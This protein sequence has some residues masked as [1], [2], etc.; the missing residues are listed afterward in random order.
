MADPLSTGAVL[1]NRPD[2]KAAAGQ[3]CE[4]TVWL[5]GPKGVAQFDHLPDSDCQTTSGRLESSGICVMASSGQREEKLVIDA[6]PLGHGN[7][8]HG[9]AD[10]LSIELAINGRRFLADSGTR[11]YVS[12][13]GDRNRFRGTAAHNT[14]EVD[15]IEQGEPSGPFAWK[16]LPKVSVDR[17]IMGSTFD[18]FSGRHDGY[19][20]LP[21]PVMHKRSVFYLK[22]RFWLVLD[23]VEGEGN[24]Q[25]AVRWHASPATSL[26]SVGPGKAVFKR[27]EGPVLALLTEQGQEWHPEIERADLS[28]VYG[29]AEECLVLRYFTETSLPAELATLLNPLGLST[30]AESELR[31]FSLFRQTNQDESGS[32]YLYEGPGERHRI[33][34]SGR[35]QPWAMNLWASDARLLYC[36]TADGGSLHVVICDGSFV[37]WNERSILKCDRRMERWELLV[38]QSGKKEFCSDETVR[39]DIDMDVLAGLELQQAE[40]VSRMEAG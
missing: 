35:P 29:S 8:G 33:F 25:L 9:H 32:S 40:V 36:G 12:D 26:A 24:H 37:K 1:F 2:F 14:L 22:G 31:S 11:C 27:E 17:W 13:G 34:F 30:P 23:R 5:M 38:G 4:E 16:S 6:G 15:G 28:E 10:A 20:R 21:H 39:R 7:S 18:F 19:C 3:L